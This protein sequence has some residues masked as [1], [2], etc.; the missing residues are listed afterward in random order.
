MYQKVGTVEPW[1]RQADQGRFE[2]TKAD[3]D[4]MLFKVPSLR[5]IAK[6]APYFHDG[7][8]PDL[9]NAVKLMAK[10]QLGRVLSDDD[11]QAIVTWLGALT[12]ELPEEYIKQPKLPVSTAT[13]PAADPS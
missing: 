1:P 9:K 11:A 6:T 8:E 7:S 12:G 5:N 13:T 3:S 2:V 10:H 4:K